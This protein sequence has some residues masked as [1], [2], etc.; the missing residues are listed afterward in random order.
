M[1][2]LKVLK[3]WIQKPLFIPCILFVCVI[4][5]IVGTL[6][7]TM[8]V[9][10]TVTATTDPAS[11][12]II[13]DAGHGGEDGGTSS[14]DG[15][16]EKD[17]TLAVTLRLKAML[18]S[19]GF[20][21]KMTRETDIAVNDPNLDTVKQR[22]VSD[23]KNRLKLIQNTPNCIFISIHQNHFSE[24]KYNGTQVFYSKNHEDSKAIAE[25]IQNQVVTFI[26]PE[27]KR[28]IK[29][30]TESIYLLWN[31]NVP[32]VLVEC[33]FLSNSDEESKLK[34]DNHQQLLVDGI[35]KGIDQYFSD[36]SSTEESNGAT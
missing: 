35:V 19:A 22:K 21:V 8:P 30:A 32:A 11:R 24:S 5:G 27:N 13:L 25:D 17:I 16:K 34:T 12:I 26:Q 29:P 9:I 20:Q 23:I 10:K 14:T 15:T 33:G 3:Q 1:I 6:F 4:A 2:Q 28:E 31:T 36:D 18:E 7:L